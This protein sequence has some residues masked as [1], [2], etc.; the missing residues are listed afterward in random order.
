MKFKGVSDHKAVTKD[1][2]LVL[3]HVSNIID[4]KVSW[5]VLLVFRHSRQ[6]IDRFFAFVV[7]RVSVSTLDKQLL[8]ALRAPV[9]LH[10]FDRQM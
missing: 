4:Q 3:E 5:R 2:P 1:G 10:R 8:D 6:V 9:L 7:Y